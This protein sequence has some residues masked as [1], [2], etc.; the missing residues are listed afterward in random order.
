MSIPSGK[1]AHDQNLTDRLGAI[2]ARANI[3]REESEWALTLDGYDFNDNYPEYGQTDV[4]EAY[5]S[6]Y[7]DARADVPTLVAA[8]R[9]V[10]DLA[11]EYERAAEGGEPEHVRAANVAAHIRRAMET[12]LGEARP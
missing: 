4:I 10:V 8:L 1:P 12:A 3:S 6:G 9:A 2:E 5:R 11:D 7:Q